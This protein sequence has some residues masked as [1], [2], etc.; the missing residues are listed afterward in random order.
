MHSEPGA[1][2]RSVARVGWLQV[3]GDWRDIYRYTVLSCSCEADAERD[4]YTAGLGC[5]GGDSG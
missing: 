3:R 2:R 1:A 5:A 4:I